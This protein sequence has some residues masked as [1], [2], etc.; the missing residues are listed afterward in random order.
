MRA[1]EIEYRQWETTRARGRDRYIWTVGVMGW[2][3]TTGILWAVAMSAMSGWDHLP[4]LFPLALIGFAGGG[5]VFG[6][7]TWR[8]NE[9]R[10]TRIQ[11]GQAVLPK[12]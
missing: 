11:R 10:H 1:Q 4:V 9:C 7:I 8:M 5:Y 12:A 6:A 2:G 3:M